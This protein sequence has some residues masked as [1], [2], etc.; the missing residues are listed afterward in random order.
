MKYAKK[1][2]FTT[3]GCYCP[4]SFHKYFS[5]QMYLL[6]ITLMQEYKLVHFMYLQILHTIYALLDTYCRSLK[7]LIFTECKY[8]LR[9]PNA[10][11]FVVFIIILGLVRVRSALQSW[12]SGP[13]G[14]RNRKKNGNIM[15]VRG[16]CD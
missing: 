9:T 10:P 4:C 13:T 8:L 3:V 12:Y 7:D 2:S 5:Y 1:Y 16:E 11:Y 15:G 14:P 6:D